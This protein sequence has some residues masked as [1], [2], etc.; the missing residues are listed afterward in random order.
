LIAWL[1]LPTALAAGQ[2]PAARERQTFHVSKASSDITVD[3]RLDEPAWQNALAIPLEFETRPGENTKPPVETHCLVTYDPSR[4]YVAFRAY[5]PDPGSIRAHLS[6][7][8]TAFDDDF[9]GIVFDTFNDERRAFEFFVNPL[10]VQMDLFNDDVG[11][12]ETSSWDAIWESAGRITDHGYVVEVA[13]P[14]HQLRFPSVDGVQTWG[15]DAL[16]F[17][18][19]SD[20]HRISSHPLDRDCTDP[21]RGPNRGARRLSQRQAGGRRR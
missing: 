13:I 1:A 15:F 16:R 20:R 21:H 14:F 7:R 5:D 17:Y 10:G 2:D 6:D 8:D 18:P 4:V 11:G 19:R 9:V 12:N 3:A